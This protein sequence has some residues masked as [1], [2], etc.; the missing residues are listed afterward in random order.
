[1]NEWHPIASAPRDGT[2]IL[3]HRFGYTR[4]DVPI[5]ARFEVK[6]DGFKGWWDDDGAY[7]GNPNHWK[8]LEPTKM[9]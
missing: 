4:W 1:M 5:V 3:V 2:R 8:P 9:N 7:V 6:D